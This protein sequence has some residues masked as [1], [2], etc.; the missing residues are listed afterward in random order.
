MT[1]HDHQCT[2]DPAVRATLLRIED[3]LHEVASTLGAGSFYQERRHLHVAGTEPAK[4]PQHLAEVLD[5]PRKR[6]AGT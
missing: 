5:F 1:N 4:P 3:V 6:A 2:P